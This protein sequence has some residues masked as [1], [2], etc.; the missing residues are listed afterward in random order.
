MKSHSGTGIHIRTLKSN[1]QSTYKYTFI[2]S[3][4]YTHT[5]THTHTQ[6]RTSDI[7]TA[8][9]DSITFEFDSKE[10]VRRKNICTATIENL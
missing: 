3:H 10:T 2:K 6:T 7:Y 5:H 9:Y 8:L 1:L 4:T